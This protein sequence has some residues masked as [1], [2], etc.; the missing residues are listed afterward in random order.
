ML[1]NLG[2]FEAPNQR[3][4]VHKHQVVNVEEGQWELQYTESH[5]PMDLQN[6]RY[7]LIDT[8]EASL[9]R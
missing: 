2:I 6:S 4:Q 9:K 3:K 1:T 8:S 7:I 5:H